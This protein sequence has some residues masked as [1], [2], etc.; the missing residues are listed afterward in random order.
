MTLLR[1][2]TALPDLLVSQIAAGEVIERPASVLKELLE[3]SIDA[4]AQNI[5]IRLEGGGIKRIMIS[6]DGHGIAPEQLGL[7]LTQHATSKIAS[8]EDLEHVASMGFRGEALASI[9]SVSRLSITS[10]TDQCAHAW[11]IQAASQQPQA[12]AGATGTT[13]D[14][15]QLFDSVPA[16]RKFLRTENTEYTHCLETLARIAMANPDVAFRL[17][18]NNKLQRNWAAAGMLQRINDVL[19]EQ[20]ANEFL[21][22]EQSQGI[23]SLA[24]VISKPA[25]ARNRADRQYLYVNG[26]YVNDRTVAHAIRQAY[27]DVLHGDRKPAYV[28]FINIDPNLVDVNVHPAKHEVR[29]RDSG[30]VHSFVSK[31]LT[32]TLATYAGQEPSVETTEKFNPSASYKPLTPLSAPSHQFD[33][34]DTNTPSDTWKSLYAPLP[35]NNT[36]QPDHPF[37]SESEGSYAKPYSAPAI[38]NSA[39]SEQ[40]STM[41]LGMAIAQL[42]GIYILAQ[43]AHGLLIVDMHAAHERVV[44][45]KMK[46]LMETSSLPV[47]ELLVP[48]VF[49]TTEQDVSLAAEH[50]QTLNDLGITIYPIGPSTLAIKAV[51]SL[52][53]KGDIETMIANILTD[54]ATAGSSTHVAQQHNEILATMACHGSVRANRQLTLDE[55]NAL[56]R[57]MEQTERADQCNHGRPTWVQWSI[58]DLDRMFWRGQ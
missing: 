13:I 54:L 37:K 55:M 57:E 45:E 56:L 50:Q 20:H 28:L 32:Q 12:A 3:N 24:G 31:T 11:Q 21:L 10:R 40:P 16:R 34:R 2:I 4:H 42:H 53:A 38:P 15:R 29:F 27:T 14:V 9:A 48:V 49:E 39:Y 1:P 26:R 25:H 52:L 46:K 23:I 19:G 44:Y 8:L 18:H 7:A 58:K 35:N 30:A 5:E 17:F 36:N 51:P 43:N 33:L 41:P 47:Q 22:V 6:D